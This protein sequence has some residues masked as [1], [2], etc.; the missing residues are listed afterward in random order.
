M[1]IDI[2]K[3]DDINYL[4]LDDDFLNDAKKYC[5][6]DDNI[7]LKYRVFAKLL[8]FNELDKAQQFVDENI[9]G[10]NDK[11]NYL[12]LYVAIEDCIN[13]V[14]DENGDYFNATDLQKDKIY[15]PIPEMI[16]FIGYILDVSDHFNLSKIYNPMEHIT[17][18]EEDCSGQKGCTFDCSVIRTLLDEYANKER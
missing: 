1:N 10:F 12:L 17:D 9:D 18:L 7:P 16:R 13:N 14:V 2:D 6:F 5:S 4:G 8:W 11:Y 3:T 15:K